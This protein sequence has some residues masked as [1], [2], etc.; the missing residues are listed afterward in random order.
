MMRLPL[1]YILRLFQTLDI[2]SYL[3]EMGETRSSR[4]PPAAPHVPTVSTT[5]VVEEGGAD[6]D[7][8]AVASEDL[9]SECT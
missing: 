4:H 8:V 1:L 6:V 9:S 2:I 3:F 5:Y 7:V